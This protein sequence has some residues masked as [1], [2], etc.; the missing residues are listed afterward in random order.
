VEH[1]LP[2]DKNKVEEDLLNLPIED[3]SEEEGKII[4]ETSK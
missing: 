3:F 2:F 4:V 1:I